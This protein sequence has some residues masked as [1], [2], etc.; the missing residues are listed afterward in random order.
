MLLSKPH[1]STYVEAPS[2]QEEILE[3]D[4]V[5]P[6][7]FDVTFPIRLKTLKQSTIRSSR[8]HL[9]LLFPWLRSDKDRGI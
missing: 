9:I 5:C 4:R 7:H 6:D 1:A 2:L 8:P 3:L